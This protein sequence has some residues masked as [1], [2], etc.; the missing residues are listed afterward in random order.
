MVVKMMTMIL[1]INFT[2]M[3]M[4][5]MKTMTIVIIMM[6][7]MT[8]SQHWELTDSSR[9]M[10]ESGVGGDV[11][12][13]HDD[14]DDGEYDDDDDD[15]HFDNDDVDSDN[16]VV[17]KMVMLT[18]VM[19][20]TT[21]ILLTGPQHWGLI[22]PSWRM[23][24]TGKFQSPIDIRPQSLLFDPNLR[25]MNVHIPSSVSRLAGWLAGWLSICLS[26][27]LSVCQ[28]YHGY[29]ACSLTPTSAV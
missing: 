15:D 21:M 22:N 20:T 17:M 26:V 18:T 7:T 2:T 13:D 1:K 24:E 19:I 27:C 23:C 28:R 16:K 8:R 25:R 29:R 12:G 5:T 4:T 6:T 10:W 9:R 3:M 14:D 11:G